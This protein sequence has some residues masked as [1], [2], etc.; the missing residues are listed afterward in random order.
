MTINSE[1][2]TSSAMS[3][4]TGLMATMLNCRVS[5]QVNE[6]SVKYYCECMLLTLFTDIIKAILQAPESKSP[7]Q[8]DLM[9][10]IILVDHIYFI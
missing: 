1:L 8:E 3:S 4:Q 10:I 9:A 6:V 5:R 2:N 7:S